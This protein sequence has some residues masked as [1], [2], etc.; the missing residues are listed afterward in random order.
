MT[1]SR[2]DRLQNLALALEVFLTQIGDK[3]V[4]SLGFIEPNA[5][6]F[7]QILPTTWIGLLDSGYLEDV[8]N[9]N[10]PLCKLTPAGSGASIS[11]DRM[12][13]RSSGSDSEGLQQS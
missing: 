6:E 3:P 13:H 1:V 10:Y 8:G 4:C 2:D 9:E 11:R 12:N 7:A 5:A